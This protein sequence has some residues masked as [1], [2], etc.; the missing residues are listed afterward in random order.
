MG[1]RVGVDAV[2][3]AWQRV[4]PGRRLDDRRRVQPGR[5]GGHLGELRR[6]LA[7]R[8][9]LGLVIDQPERG[10]VPERGGAAVAEYHVVAV[11]EREE[12]RHP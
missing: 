4:G 8:Q 7:E 5:R 6:E 11:R 2:L 1:Q 9:V 12:L 10:D 3:G